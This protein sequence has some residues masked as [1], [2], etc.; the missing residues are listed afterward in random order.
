MKKILKNWNN[1]LTENV[2]R[3]ELLDKVRDI[4][5]GAYNTWDDEYKI[6]HDQKFLELHDE[7]KTTARQ[8]FQSREKLSKVIRGSDIGLTLYWTDN[9][10]HGAGAPEA[11]AYVIQ[12]KLDILESKLSEDEK[13]ELK[14][15]LMKNIVD[16]VSQDRSNQVYPV[17]L[18]V[19]VGVI[20]NKQVDDAF[21]TTGEG[22]SRFVVPLLKSRGYYDEADQPK[23]PP[24]KSKR[25]KYE[26]EMSL[27]D[28]RAMMDKF[29]K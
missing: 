7:L 18:A 21:M 9:P 17:G 8:K 29:S 2:D 19:S 15:G 14:F 28:M 26:P 23:L 3:S 20:N 4:F 24:N 13:V 5:Y 22:M 25:K 16:S 27:D 12:K 10:S 1:F 6:L 11:A